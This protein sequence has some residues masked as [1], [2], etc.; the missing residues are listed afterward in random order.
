MKQDRYADGPTRNYSRVGPVKNRDP[1]K[2]YCV[3]DIEREIGSLTMKKILAGVLVG[4]L[5]LAGLAIWSG[6]A[7]INWPWRAIPDFTDVAVAVEIPNEV[8]ITKVEPIS[9]D[10]R[11]R[12]YAEVPL[13]GRRE[14][15]LF[16]RV[17]R[18][19]SITMSA[20]G[21]ID[22]CVDG[23]SARVIHRRDGTTEVLIPG[24]SIVF[25]RPRVNTVLTASSVEVEKGKVGKLTDV[26]PW[27][28][29]N[30]GLTPVA[31]AYAQNVIGSSKC[32][33][34]AYGVT[35]DILVEA[36]RDQFIQQGEDP[37]TLTVRVDGEPIFVDPL[38]VD[39][40]DVEMDL[41]GEAITCVVS[42]GALAGS[43]DSQ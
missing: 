6:S 35:E 34:A 41:S 37:E 9:L 11:A 33:Q 38:P 18:T 29:D 3:L 30:L 43:G 32:M 25:V 7:S 8:R 22:T 24:E 31:Y 20:V 2:W 12:V 28:S 26:F 5:G 4:A 36:Y 42:E 1:S 21:D 15:T 39:M 13:E 19:D 14:H 23:T 10:C 27:V 17:Y 40:G 16:D